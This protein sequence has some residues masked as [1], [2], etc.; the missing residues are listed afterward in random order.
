MGPPAMDRTGGPI[1]P[2]VN[3]RPELSVPPAVSGNPA[4]ISA[5]AAG[6]DR[7]GIQRVALASRENLML[8]QMEEL[9]QPN[10]CGP[11]HAERE[12]T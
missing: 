9:L 4:E 3:Y 1:E 6:C 2:P 10:D 5:S 11:G 12:M 8:K 7:D